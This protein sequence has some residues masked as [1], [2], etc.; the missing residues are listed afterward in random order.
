MMSNDPNMNTYATIGYPAEGG[1]GISIYEKNYPDVYLGRVGT[2]AFGISL[3]HQNRLSI[4]N[5]I[6]FRD[7]NGVARLWIDQSGNTFL[8]NAANSHAIGVD[9]SGPYIIKNSVK[10]YL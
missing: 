9:G 7:K 4:G 3:D 1:V 6:Y 5:D 8:Q 2:A 10:T